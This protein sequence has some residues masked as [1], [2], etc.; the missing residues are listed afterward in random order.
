[1]LKALKDLSRKNRHSDSSSGSEEGD[2]IDGK[3]ASSQRGFTG[4]R[5]L[6]RKFK[7]HPTRLTKEYVLMCKH[8]LGIHDPNIPWQFKDV[9]K[10]LFRTFGKM[11]G[12]HKCHTMFSTVLQLQIAGEHKHA[13][14]YTVQALKALH[15]V[16]LDQGRWDAAELLLLLG[17]TQDLANFGGTEGEMV[18][19]HG[20]QKA[21]RELKSSHA[22]TQII[23][24][25]DEEVDASLGGLGG[26]GS[27][28][29][30]PKAKG[31][32]PG[33]NP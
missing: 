3:E 33:E 12:L 28:Q 26:K 15:Q 24:E 32:K 21:L 27:R 20:F 13:T 9:S 2:W 1:M 7:K 6:R 25:G 8:T 16:A 31:G 29:G 18:A 14:A 17:E 10:K 5:K 30:K 22:R 11:R 23:E 4:I 19:I